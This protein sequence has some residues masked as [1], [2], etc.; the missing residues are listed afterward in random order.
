MTDFGRG[1]S[2]TT[3]TQCRWWP[4]LGSEELCAANAGAERDV[5]RLRRTYPLVVIA[6]WTAVLA[7]FLNALRIPQVPRTA[8]VIVAMS[9][10]LLA[11]LAHRAIFNSAPRAL[12]VL[13][14]Q[15]LAPV[16][17][18]VAAIVTAAT[19]STIAVVL[20]VLSV[21]LRGD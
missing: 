8:G 16:P 1:T 2:G 19:C 13:A 6:L 4:K 9:L 7:I 17:A 11:L 18:G 14:G 10:P 21:R 20:L 12:S 15:S 5:S 3:P